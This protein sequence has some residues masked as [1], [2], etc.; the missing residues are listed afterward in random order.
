MSSKS[1][2]KKKAAETIENA[3]KEL[4]NLLDE[5]EQEKISISSSRKR[6]NRWIKN[7]S[8]SIS[9]YV[10]ISENDNLSAFEFIKIRGTKKENLLRDIDQCQDF[11]IKMK[12]NLDDDGFLKEN[13]NEV[14]SSEQTNTKK[15]LRYVYI[16]I[17]FL[18]ALATIYYTAYIL[19]V[20]E[21]EKSGISA[22][23]D[24]NLVCT[25]YVVSTLDETLEKV[26]DLRDEKKLRQIIS[27]YELNK[28]IREIDGDI[29]F[30]LSALDFVGLENG[31]DHSILNSNKK[32]K[33][34]NEDIEYF[35]LFVID[36]DVYI[37]TYIDHA[38][39]NS[40]IKNL[41]IT[42][43]AIATEKFKIPCLV[44]FKCIEFPVEILF[45]DDSSIAYFQGTIKCKIYSSSNE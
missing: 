8:K 21:K 35:E 1:E 24:Q 2:V 45:D 39:E 22:Q 27:P 43:Y 33:R 20:L 41:E 6:L 16:L 37:V 18:A 34:D 38:I 32:S 12:G 23:P 31:E 19:G 11:L 3:S 42:L 17:T 44:P 29:Y 40:D 14:D 15:L 28:D 7:I 5:V 25:Y 30:Y 13:I 9:K 26:Q 4:Q 10:N 36:Q